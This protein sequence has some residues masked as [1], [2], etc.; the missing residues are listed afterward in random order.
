MKIKTLRVGNLWTNCYIVSSEATKE[1][2]IV[3]PG[4]DAAAII[5]EIEASNLKP[6][7]IVNTHA[8][9][10]HVGANVD[11]MLRFKI[12]AAISSL[13]HEV[14]EAW[15]PYFLSYFP[16][17]D[18][19][20]FAFERL[21]NDGDIIEVGNIKFSVISTP[22]HSR[23]S[24]C[25]Y[26]K[27]SLFSGDTLFAGDHGRTDFEGGSDEDMQRSLAKLFELPPGTKVYPGHG[28]SSTIEAEKVLYA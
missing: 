3:D 19:K 6:I 5:E 17:M 21:L 8:H 22:G 15:T 26:T 1:A 20:N 10:D 27:G 4:D 7:L 11:L 23:G 18:I 28:K 2:L 25:L 16:E 13:D 24:I 9:H 12:P 14:I